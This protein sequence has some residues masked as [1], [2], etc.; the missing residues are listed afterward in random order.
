MGHLSLRKAI[1]EVY[2]GKGWFSISD[3]MKNQKLIKLLTCSTPLTRNRVR[4]ETSGM[5]REG[6]VEGKSK[7]QNGDICYSITVVKRTACCRPQ[8]SKVQRIAL[9]LPS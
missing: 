9:G 7:K 3:A 1:C 5:I 6:V 2:S 8:F 4:D